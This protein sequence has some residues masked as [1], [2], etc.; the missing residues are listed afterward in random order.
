MHDANHIHFVTGKLAEPIVRYVVGTVAERRSFEYSIGVLPI[1]VAALM[2]PKWL[3]RHILPPPET[4]LIVIPGHLADSVDQIA[5]A[6]GQSVVAGPRDIRELPGFFGE[7]S[8]SM[9][10]YGDYAIDIIAEI[11]HAPRLERQQLIQTAQQLRSDGADVID[12]GCDPNTKWTRVYD[13][14]K[15]LCDLGFRISIDTFDVWEAAEATRGGAEL[16]LSVNASNRQAAVDWGAEVVVVPDD[17]QRAEEGL[18]ETMNFLQKN[19]VSFRLDPILEPIGCGFANSIARYHSL[20]N[21]IPD[22]PIMMGIGNLTELT[23]AD[24]AGVN[25]LLLGICEELQIRSVLTTQ[26]INWART[27]VAECDLARRLAH[28]A[29]QHRIPPKHLEE[30]LVMLRDPK[31][32]AYPA[33]V[34]TQLA[35]DIRDN[36]YRI[37]VDAQQIHLMSAGVHIRGTDPFLMMAE[38]LELP[39]SSNVDESHAFYLGFELAKALTALTLGK[40]YNQD[41]ELSWGMHTRKEERHRLPRRKRKHKPGPPHSN[42]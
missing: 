32:T 41:V 20:R 25:V 7:K 5:D 19:S 40:Q 17:L 8:R 37:L 10:D 22:V 34:L 35:A 11:N 21:L 38:L 36:N 13:V 2:T 15:E 12:L 27:S 29:V 26:V 4:E 16:V 24:S 9:E 14:A 23:D 18:I 33:D 6:I 42:R 3:L 1:T 28:Y 39:Q 30:K 31:T